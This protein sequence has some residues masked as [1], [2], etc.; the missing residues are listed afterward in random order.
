MHTPAMGRV[1]SYS[2]PHPESPGLMQPPWGEE[3]FKSLLFRVGRSRYEC[4]VHS[5]SEKSEQTALLGEPP[6]VSALWPGT[7]V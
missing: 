2:R 5:I 3:G 4:W 7:W 1:F 6:A